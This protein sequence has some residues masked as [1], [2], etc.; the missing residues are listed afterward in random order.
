MA[1]RVVVFDGGPPLLP[2]AA[3]GSAARQSLSPLTAG[4]DANTVSPSWAGVRCQLPCEQ[5]VGRGLQC[6][7][8]VLQVY[9]V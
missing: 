7:S 3:K 1:D 5:A 8:A 9:D 2:R 4:W 6:S